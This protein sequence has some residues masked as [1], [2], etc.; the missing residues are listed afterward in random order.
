MKHPRA[1]RSLL[2]AGAVG[3]V[4][5]HGFVPASASSAGDESCFLSAI[6]AARSAAGAAPLAI[7]GDLLRIS[8]VWSQTMATAAQLYHDPNLTKL[9]PSNWQALGEN[10]GTGPTCDSLAQ[11]FMNSPEHRRNILD[12]AFTTVGVGVV[13]SADGTVW[14]TEDFMGTGGALPVTVVVQPTPRVTVSPKVTVPDPKVTVPAPRVTVPDPRVKSP[15]PRAVVPTPSP[16]HTEPAATPKPRPSVPAPSPS[17]VAVV[18]RPAPRATPIP[19]ATPILDLIPT[20]AGGPT[21]N[22][23]STAPAEHGHGV[24]SAIASLLSHL[25]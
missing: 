21:P 2:I 25:L 10:V 17:E 8:R 24:F 9:A 19:V 16:S 15:A 3:A 18:E 14:V 20:P 5:L 11:A 6:N 13:D 12:P 22:P 7:Q 1:V 23:A 4:A